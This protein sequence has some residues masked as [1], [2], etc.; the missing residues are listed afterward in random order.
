MPES[1]KKKTKLNEIH[2]RDQIWLGHIKKNSWLASRPPTK[3]AP[4]RIFFDFL[5]KKTP[6]FIDQ[7]ALI[8]VVFLSTVVNCVNKLRNCVRK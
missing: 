5:F 4:L 2:S 6:T 7:G 3:K 8:Y 1:H